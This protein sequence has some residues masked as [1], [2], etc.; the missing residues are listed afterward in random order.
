MFRLP[1]NKVHTFNDEPQSDLQTIRSLVALISVGRGS[2][3]AIVVLGLLSSF[4]EGFGLYLFLPLLEIVTGGNEAGSLALPGFVRAF[5]PGDG[6]AQAVPVIILLVLLSIVLKNVVAYANAAL[7]AWVN[8][9]AG[10]ELRTTFYRKILSA[11][12][13]H[14][15][16]ETSGRIAN[17][18]LSESWRAVEALGVLF[19]IVVQACAALVL[20]CVLFLISWQGT[21]LVIPISLG[22]FAA[23]HL[24]TRM[25]RRLG[26][27][28]VKANSAFVRQFWETMEGLRTIRNFGAA[29]QEQ[30]RFSAIS[31]RTRDVFAKLQLA[32]NLSGP[33]FEILAAAALALWVAVLT[34]VGANIANLAVF[35]LVVYRLQPRLRF[36]AESRA[37][38]M[39]LGSSVREIENVGA[40]CLASSIPSGTRHIEGLSEGIRF[41]NVS[42]SY[43]GRTG[44]AL[45]GID[46]LFRKNSSTALVGPSG[47]GKSTLIGLLCRNMDPI[48]GQVLVDGVDLRELVSGDWRALIGIV[49]QEVHL[50]STS[51]AENIAYGMP[52]VVDAEVRAAA[53]LAHC[54]DF[55]SLL[56]QGYETEVGDK[57]IRLSG[58]QR[59]RIA[60]ARALIRKPALLILDEAT[61]ALDSES[62]AAIQKALRDV[63]AHVT[64]VT[65][66]H[67][68]ST[69]HSADNIVVLAGGRVV[70]QG[71][72]Q[73]L[74]NLDG[75]FAA[76]EDLQ[77]SHI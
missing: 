30:R 51:I 66:A 67:R 19:R 44:E 18:M 32:G 65:I 5:L 69:I 74:R 68:L 6:A 76:M 24:V 41:E 28:A 56:P 62:E 35:M 54:H 40:A 13:G 45:A 16:N 21:L 57:G 77:L 64:M 43:P 47:A 8:C 59:Q 27:E 4:F 2:V 42:F 58:G 61:N 36:L 1:G 17:A 26:A 38:L 63:A 11:S 15:E 34:S 7:F 39:Q 20:F 46:L 60:L 53:K 70:E 52:Q 73:T 10:H 9:S 31:E 12:I 29:D 55:I 71:N 25:N 50:F 49:P 14:V 75:H 48:E 22:I 3:V 72:L 23:L 37:S 33:V